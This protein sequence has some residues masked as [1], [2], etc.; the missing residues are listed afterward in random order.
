VHESLEVEGQIGTMKGDLVH[1]TDPDLEYYFKKF[2][3][4]TT[5]AAEDMVKDGVKPGLFHLLA[6]PLATF[7]KMYF[8]K[9]GYRDGL[10]GFILCTLSS[11][12]VFTKFAKAIFAWRGK[13]RP[14][15][16]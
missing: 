12:Y 3:L 14:P 10:E 1:H 7:V 16:P 8:L 2:N 13:E 4:Y 11:F 9:H 6:R 5:L 15:Q